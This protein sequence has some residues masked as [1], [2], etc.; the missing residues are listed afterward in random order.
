MAHIVGVALHQVAQAPL[1]EERVEVLVLAALAQVQDDVGAVVIRTVALPRRSG[2]D[3]VA[4]HAVALPGVCLIGAERA[5]DH[6]HLGRNHEAGVEAHA[7]LADDIDVGA[8]ML[9]VLL[10]EGL[11]AGMRDGAEVLV[12]LGLGHADAVV[13]DGDGAGILVEGEADR[14]ILGTQVDRIVR[15]RLELELVDGVACVGDE[16]AQEDLAVGVD[17]VDHEVEELLALRLELLHGL[18]RF[19]LSIKKGGAGPPVV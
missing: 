15:K 16:L 3:G 7:E 12:E 9:G 13:R 11:G 18:N 8:L 19:L 2:L 1:R 10:L 14:K 4:A 5:R 17:R 6:A